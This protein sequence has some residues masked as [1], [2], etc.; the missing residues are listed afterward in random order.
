M[1][2]LKG[3]PAG[4]YPRQLLSALGATP[5][6]VLPYAQ[7]M[8]LMPIEYRSVGRFETNALKSLDTVWAMAVRDG[9]VI[10]LLPAGEAFLRQCRM[11]VR[12]T[13]VRIIGQKAQPRTVPPFKPMGVSA[14]SKMMAGGPQRPGMDDLRGAPSLM[15]GARVSHTVPVKIKGDA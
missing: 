3:P 2:R 15:G 5:N 10:R 14:F 13:V 12:P 11:D 7:A 6:G 1:S 8:L 4:S 9:D